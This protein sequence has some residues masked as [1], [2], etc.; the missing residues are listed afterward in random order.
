MRAVWRETLHYIPQL[1]PATG[2]TIFYTVTSMA[3]AL[4]VGLVVALA[5]RSRRR[6][7][8]FPFAIYVEVI[9]GTPLLLQVFYIYYVLPHFG[10]RLTAPVAG[11]TALSMNYAA[12]LSEVYRS[13][14]DAVDPG[15]GEAA[16][17]LGMRR[18]TAMRTIILPQAVRIV[19]PPLGN[20]FV[21]LFKDTAL[22][23]TIA[24]LELM[25]SAQVLAAQTFNYLPI[26]TAALILYF[27]ISYPAALGVRYLERRLK[28]TGT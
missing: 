8:T 9:R 26:Y 25:F 14:L 13:G 6:Y 28:P 20:Y 12:Y 5:R 3:I 23:S 19:I 18:R 17:A 4:T 11:I 7:V 22:L 24:V 10:I 15:Q 1:L 21:A 16:A 27:V 2:K